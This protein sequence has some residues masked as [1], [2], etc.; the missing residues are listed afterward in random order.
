MLLQPRLPRLRCSALLDQQLWYLGRDIH[1]PSGNA[2]RAYGFV[3][4]RSDSGHGSSSYVLEL[5]AESGALP[6]QLICWGFGVAVSSS[7]TAAS[8]A[9]SGWAGI[10]VERFGWS[11]R[12]L[13]QPLSPAIHQVSDLPTA[14]RPVTNVEQEF[15]AQAELLMAR[16]F[17]AYERWVLATLGQPHRDA[18]L[19]DAPRHKRHRFLQTPGLALAWD[20][21]GESVQARITH[22][23]T[24]IRSGQ[25]TRAGRSAVVRVPV[26]PISAC[27]D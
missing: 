25:R 22:V 9:G 7:T 2:L 18:A 27:R 4:H 11:S 13:L 10:V 24:S 8:V 12:L 5:A 26:A 14:P 15:A 20:E 19:R 6:I 1:G 16:A 17:A 21:C 3:R 23:G